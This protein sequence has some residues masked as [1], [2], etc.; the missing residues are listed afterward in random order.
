MVD[1]DNRTLKKLDIETFYV[2]PNILQ[3]LLHYFQTIKIVWFGFFML[4][5]TII[6]LENNNNYKNI[7]VVCEYCIVLE[8]MKKL[9]LHYL[10]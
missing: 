2:N 1:I 9:V 7:K 10:Y 8:F 5:N 3:I 4:Q 6:V